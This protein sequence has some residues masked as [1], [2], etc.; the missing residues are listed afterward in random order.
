M[1]KKTSLK[2]GDC[3]TSSTTHL[4][5]DNEGKRMGKREEREVMLDRQ[6]SMCRTFI[7]LNY[8]VKC[9]STKTD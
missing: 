1:Y 7:S 3:R 8:A 2:T 5:G 6:D 9:D 4:V